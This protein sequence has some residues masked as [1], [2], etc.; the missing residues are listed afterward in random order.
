MFFFLRIFLCP[1]LLYTNQVVTYWTKVFRENFLQRGSTL[2]LCKPIFILWK[3]NVDFCAK[4]SFSKSLKYRKKK[5]ITKEHPTFKLNNSKKK[6]NESQTA[7]KL[8]QKISQRCKFWILHPIKKQKIHQLSWAGFL[9]STSQRSES[10]RCR[11][12]LSNLPAPCKW[13]WSQVVILEQNCIIF[14]EETISLQFFIYFY[15]LKSNPCKLKSLLKNYCN[16]KSIP[17]Q[18]LLLTL[19]SK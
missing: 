2:L 19:K 13:L 3:A 18:T 12:Q 6:K 7:I 11:L 14:L 15:L 1:Y 8:H 5:E 4:Y 17:T 9:Q 16:L 10:C